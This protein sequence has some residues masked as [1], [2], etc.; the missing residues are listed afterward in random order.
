MNWLTVLKDTLIN[1]VSFYVSIA[2]KCRLCRVSVGSNVG[3]YASIGEECRLCRVFLHFA[4]ARVCVILSLIMYTYSIHSSIKSIHSLH[5]IVF[6]SLKAIT[7]TLHYP[8]HPTLNTLNTVRK[9]SQTYTA[10]YV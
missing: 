5:F 7:Q 1:Q 6:D 2:S 3:F 9:F 4:H 8:T 10:R